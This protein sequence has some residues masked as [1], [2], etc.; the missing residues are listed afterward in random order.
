[1]SLVPPNADL[2]PVIG[3]EA[4]A[5]EWARNNRCDPTPE[6]Q[7]PIGEVQPLFWTDCVSP[8]QLYTIGNGGHVWPGSPSDSTINFAATDVIWSFF[9]R[10]AYPG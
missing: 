9:T 5:A 10:H 7:A 2:P 4:W 8:V 3:V 6:P 1:M